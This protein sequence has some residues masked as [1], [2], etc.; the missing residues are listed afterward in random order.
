MPV[1]KARFYFLLYIYIS[2]EKVQ[3]LISMLESL[4]EIARFGLKESAVSL[5]TLHNAELNLV[6]Y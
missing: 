4:V 2:R 6:D 5:N 1:F 3:L